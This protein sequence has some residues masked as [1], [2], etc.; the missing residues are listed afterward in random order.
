MTVSGT[1]SNTD[2]AVQSNT[3]FL[4]RPLCMCSKRMDLTRID[5]ARPEIGEMEVRYYQCRYCGNTRMK[6]FGERH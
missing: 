6:S 2:S 3:D 5:P 4:D 1:Q